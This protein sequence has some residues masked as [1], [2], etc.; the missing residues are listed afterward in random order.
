[1]T[2]HYKNCIV[3]FCGVRNLLTTVQKCLS[4]NSHELII[5]KISLFFPRFGCEMH[6]SYSSILIF[7]HARRALKQ[8]QIIHGPGMIVMS[9]IVF[10]KGTTSETISNT[11][12]R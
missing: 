4:S 10:L 9:Q 7:Q 5:A 11:R 3:K 6:T 8:E 2:K 1:M 12:L